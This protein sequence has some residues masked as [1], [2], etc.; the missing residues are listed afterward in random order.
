MYLPSGVAKNTTFIADIHF[1]GITWYH[2]PLQ[3]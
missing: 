3:Q 2:Q 1:K